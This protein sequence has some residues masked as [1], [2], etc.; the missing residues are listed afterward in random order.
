MDLYG[1]EDSGY[2]SVVL[3]T[4]IIGLASAVACGQ[5]RSRQTPLFVNALNRELK[6]AMIGQDWV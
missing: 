6:L 5:V 3:R 4:K 1:A 2:Y